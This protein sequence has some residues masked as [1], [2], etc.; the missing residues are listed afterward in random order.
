MLLR[1][2]CNGMARRTE[3]AALWRFPS[4]CRPLIRLVC[5]PAPF[6]CAPPI[7][8]HRTHAHQL[9]H[10]HTQTRA[11]KRARAHARMHICHTLPHQHARTRAHA[12][13]PHAASTT[14]ARAH[15][16]SSHA[17]STTH[18]RAHANLSHA[19]STTHARALAPLPHAASTT[20]ARTWLPLARVCSERPAKHERYDLDVANNYLTGGTRGEPFK[21]TA[22]GAAIN[23]QFAIRLHPLACHVA[24][25]WVG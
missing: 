25:V 5:F 10:T 8:H 11:R 4:V 2:H 18:T 24:Y 6:S 13:L 12:P 14:H 20:H 3:R 21:C 15:A 23:P 16:P 1:T 9:T 7:H 17:A 22:K 19:A